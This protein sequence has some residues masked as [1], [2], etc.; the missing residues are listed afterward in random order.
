[1]AVTL[2]PSAPLR[3]LVRRCVDRSGI[4]GFSIGIAQRHGANPLTVRRRVCEI[5]SGRHALIDLWWADRFCVACGVMLAHVYD[6]S[7]WEDWAGD[8]LEF[9]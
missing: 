1:M 5:L 8:D 2:L 6:P 7:E 9:E 3:P 4:T